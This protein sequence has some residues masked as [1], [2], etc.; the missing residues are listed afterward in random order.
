MPTAAPL[1]PEQQELA[2]RYFEWALRVAS[3]PKSNQ[4]HLADEIESAAL[5]GLVKAARAYV[6][7]REVRF[8]SYAR[9]RVEGEISDALIREQAKGFRK[10]VR[11]PPRVS[12]IQVSEAGCAILEGAGQVLGSQPDPDVGTQ[13]AEEES[14]ELAIATVPDKFKP[15][16]RLLFVHDQSLTRAAG[17]L[18]ISPALASLWLGVAAKSLG[19]PVRGR[20]RSRRRR[21][22]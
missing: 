3:F 15:L 17:E 13:L 5:L 11:R 2:A 21:A 1:T 6:P 18:G 14:F 7:N 16:L 19:A 12:P 4:P 22:C 9:H 20:L 10:S 8:E